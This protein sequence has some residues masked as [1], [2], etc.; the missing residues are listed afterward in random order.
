MR[1]KR[2]R[3]TIIT[4]S[5][6]DMDAIGYAW[7]M[8]RYA[9]GF[10]GTQIKL[11]AFSAIDEEALDAADSVGDIGGEFIP[12]R[13]RFDHHHLPG[14]VSTSTCA[15]MMV[16]RH[17]LSLG[18]DVAH[19]QPLIE[20]IYQGDLG[21]AA[22]PTGIHALLWGAGL[23]RNRV[24]GQRLTDYEF[25]AVGFELL[26]RSTAWLKRKA[27]VKA[28]LAEKVVWKSADG[29]VWAIKGGNASTNF[30]AYEEG[31]RV[32]VFEG[33]PI[34]LPEG[35][36]YPVG[37]FRAA[38]WQEPHLGLVINEI[39]TD[40][41]V[42]SDEVLSELNL[43]FRHNDGFFVGRGTAK[44]PVFEPPKADLMEIAKAIS[45]VWRR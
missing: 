32:A 28:D 22:D 5:S 39:L 37:A 40:S 16:W 27:E 2:G 29:L 6:P 36:T 44:G 1:E 33:D 41:I 19:L 21:K 14:S 11:M 7:L 10:E 38:E 12:S 3:K 18:E 30:A 45:S 15:A 20:V 23:M 31:C 24:T 13:W 43:W 26:D 4:H 34:Q 9:P 17:L 35:T 42:F 8:V 25:M